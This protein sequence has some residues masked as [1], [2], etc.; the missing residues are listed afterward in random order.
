MADRYWVGGTNSWNA[1]AGTKWATFSGGPGGASVPTAAD[2]VFF[3]QTGPYTVST[4]GNA[5][6]LDLTVSVPSI[7]F[8][9]PGT[10]TISGSLF[11][12]IGTPS[13][14][15]FSSGITFNS[16]VTGR[17]INTNDTTIGNPSVVL[18]GVGGSW[19]LGSGYIGSNSFTV[20]NGTFNTANINMII[21]GNFNSSNSNTRTINL[22]SST[23]LLA[24]SWNLATITGLT[25]S[26]ASSTINIDGNPSFA[27]G[28]LTYGTV[29]FTN[30]SLISATITGSNIFST[31]SF[32]ARSAA[33]IGT[34]SLGATQIVTTSFS[35]QS[36]A[37]DPTRRLFIF[38][39]VVGTARIINSAS[40]TIFGADFRDITG[41]GA[42]SWTDSSRTNYWGDCK[43]NSGITFASGRSAFWNLAGAQNWSA[44]GWALT[45][46]GTPAAANFPLAQDTA[47]FTNAGSVTGTITV[48]ANWNIGTLDMS[49]RTSAMTLAT[50]TTTPLLYGN[51]LN[52]SGT[53][54][55]GTG[56]L[57]FVGRTTQSITSASK[58]FT[59][60]ITIN[61]LGGTV[62]LVDALT[63]DAARTL[64]LT[65]G[66]FDA[67]NQNVT[68]GL[69]DSSNSNIRT[70]TMGSGTWTLSGIAGVWNTLTTINLTFNANTANIVLSDTSTT[71]RTFTGGALAYNKLT[72]GGTTGSS[73][74]NITGNAGLSFTEIAST[75]TV[76]HT[77][78]LVTSG[79]SVA[80]WTVTG[81]AGNIVTVISD[82]LRSQ[83]TITYTGSGTISM[84][85]MSITD[86]NFSYTLG[87][88][89][90]YLVYAGA[91]ST[92]GGNNNG[93]AF[94]DG[95]TQKAY[96]LTTG[97]SW[98]VPADWS[99]ASNTIHL[100]GA[101]GSGGTSV[102][103]GNNRAAGGGGGGGGYTV[104]NNQTLSGNIPYAI[105][106]STSGSAGGAT[107]FNT[108]NTAG[109]GGVGTATTTPTS[110]SGAGGT[111]VTFNGGNGGVGAF[112]TAASTGYGSGGGGGAGGPNGV[113][114]NGGNGFGG[115]AGT[116]T[117]GGGGG[118]GGGSNGTNGIS[119]VGG[120]GGNN[121]NGVGGATGGAG[122]GASGTFGGGGAGGG[123]GTAGGQGGIGIDIS[124]TIGGGGGR[125]GQGGIG[126]AT[127]TNTGL[128][129]GGG[130]GGGVTTGAT[131]SAGGPGSQGVIFIVYS[132]GGAPVS[133]SNFFF[134]IGSFS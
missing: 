120:N 105:G 86:I 84:D 134:F 112:G 119:A 59:Q 32:V 96:R 102:A 33:G 5:F 56:I 61:T 12:A 50:G 93:I 65:A 44:T 90:P 132:P 30:P 69:F 46:T 45:S 113:G 68:V 16:T 49:G 130:A 95:L 124:N 125:G 75:K 99:N 8:S 110:S 109:G 107:T 111:G 85:Y 20:T 78:S 108:T 26:G 4:S 13:F 25:F 87:A 2:N 60:P 77:I 66:T 98:T 129:G 67:F 39:S 23:I 9:G 41:A 21:G 47:T 37:T 27:G 126:G 114:G 91:N 43:G 24:N 52:G 70:L 127:S 94:I 22:G 57:F 133:N 72:I 123:S 15:G 35:V 80:N 31:L 76:A 74:L 29:N 79:F 54:L 19:T 18:N 101:G 103:S 58:T 7:T 106:T 88:S 11:L 118:N 104:L 17:T 115:L 62:S 38:S 97:T 51:W 3:D 64:T 117:G 42:A 73:T 128:Y 100:I 92:N 82:T 14:N 121:F 63:M 53:T 36:G 55:T 40:N 83:R 71:L 6:C 116:I 1:T 122:P 48:N 10:L 81:T 28:G 89:N 131:T 34:L